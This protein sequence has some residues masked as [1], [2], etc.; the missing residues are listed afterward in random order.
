MSKHTF[1]RA[2]LS[3]AG[4]NALVDRGDMRL[5]E[6][7]HRA[8]NSITMAIALLRLQQRQST[9]EAVVAALGDAIQRLDHLAR[10]HELLSRIDGPDAQQVDMAA[11]LIELCANFT[12]LE[13]AGVR[14]VVE[15]DIERVVLDVDRAISVALFAGEAI[16]NAMKHAY[17]EGVSGSVRVG[18][19]VMRG[20][21]QLSVIDRGVGFSAHG[22]VGSMGVRL[23][24]E[25]AGNLNGELVIEA[26]PETRVLLIFPRVGRE[27]THGAT[28]ARMPA[29]APMSAR[30]ARRTRVRV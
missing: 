24:T 10:I 28:P 14:I 30:Q 11:Y 19:K 9:G 8:K 7:N 2:P 13:R 23:M 16:S 29:P 20:G 26:E 5:Q 25:L 4:M 15:P 27:A 22:R 3:V 12:H 17:P 6:V 1:R 18:L 21:V